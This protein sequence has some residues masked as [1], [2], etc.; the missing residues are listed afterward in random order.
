MMFLEENLTGGT[1]ILFGSYAKGE[2]IKTSDIDIAVIE[3]KKKQLNLEK[4]EFILNR[5][6]NIQF[7]DSWRN[8]HKYLKNNILNGIVIAGSVDL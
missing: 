6:I 2:D 8:I 4:F 1:I 5:E 3:R 7:Y